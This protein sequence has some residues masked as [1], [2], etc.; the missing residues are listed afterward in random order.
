METQRIGWIGTHIE[1]ARILPVKTT[2]SPGEDV[3]FE[4]KLVIHGWPDWFPGG[5]QPIELYSGGVIVETGK[6]G[7]DGVF[8]I[9]IKL[10]FTPGT[11][12]Y[13]AY[14]PGSGFP[15]GWDP[16]SSD[17]I[18]VVVAGAPPSQPP[19][20]QPPGA[21]TQETCEAAG[22]YWYDGACHSSPKPVPWWE[23]YKYHLVAAGAACMVG[24]V[25]VVALRKR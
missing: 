14:Y 3:V 6:T 8:R 21:Y 24:L 5:D 12:A 15:A 22:Y 13:R 25:A 4:G 20:S 18:T 23:K 10:P 2:Y 17:T 11:Y 9:P 1:G 16:C 7:P 19:E